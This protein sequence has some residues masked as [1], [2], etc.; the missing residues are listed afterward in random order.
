MKKMI[1]FLISFV[2]L[3]S[4]SYGGFLPTSWKKILK[5]S[6]NC[7]D[8]VSFWR[9]EKSP[10]G[11]LSLSSSSMRIPMHQVVIPECFTSVCRG[12]TLYRSIPRNDEKGSIV[13]YEV[14]IPGPFISSL[15]RLTLTFDGGQN[16]C[17]MDYT[18]ADDKDLNECIDTFEASHL[19][20][21]CDKEVSNVGSIGH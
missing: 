3:I 21:N 20:N 9:L 13:S 18:Y 7:S 6:K 8:S 15:P 14:F 10:F 4:F 12:G 1:V 19:Q 2:S 16:S 5:S 11:Y 17:F